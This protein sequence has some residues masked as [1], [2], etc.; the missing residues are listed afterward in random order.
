MYQH[1]DRM[2]DLFSMPPTP[3]EALPFL[4]V[5]LAPSNV[6]RR[7]LSLLERHGERPCPIQHYLL[8]GFLCRFLCGN[9]FGANSVS[10][11]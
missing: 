7:P 6:S 8:V 11:L 4:F 2:T 5:Q 10:H 9:R 3:K 1:K